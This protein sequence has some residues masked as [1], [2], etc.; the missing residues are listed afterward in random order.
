MSEL[1][2]RVAALEQERD[3]ARKALRSLAFDLGLPEV[4][5]PPEASLATLVTRYVRDPL[6]QHATLYG[7]LPQ[8][9]RK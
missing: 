3:A 7:S 6:R 4:A 9:R 1:E 5:W 8:R 2:A